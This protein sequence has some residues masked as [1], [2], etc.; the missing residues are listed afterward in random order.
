MNDSNSL[1]H[2]KS[3]ASYICQVE[4]RRSLLI[5]ERHGINMIIVVC[6]TQDII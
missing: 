6:G 2:T 5:H 4:S 1:A 3:K